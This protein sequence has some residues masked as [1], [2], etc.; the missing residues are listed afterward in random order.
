MKKYF[1]VLFYTVIL[2][3]TISCGDKECD[4]DPKTHLGIG[5]ICSCGGTGCTCTEQTAVI[6]GTSILIRKQ[7]GVTVA[8]MNSAVEM[9]NEMYTGFNSAGKNSFQNNI[10]EIQIGSL[11]SGISHTGKVMKT[12]YNES[13]ESIVPYLFTNDLIQ[14]N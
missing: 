10:T 2:L 7:S 11:N 9:I 13:G 5:E 12:G 4:C 8:Q 14:M 1:A 3:T 6:A